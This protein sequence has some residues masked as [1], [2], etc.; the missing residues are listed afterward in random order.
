MER[1]KVTWS[2]GGKERGGMRQKWISALLH[3]ATLGSALMCGAI[4][5]LDDFRKG[6]LGRVCLDG[7]DD[8][9]AVG[10]I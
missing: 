1:E 8:L 5:L 4:A 6:R 3:A 9:K 10:L 2:C 7:A